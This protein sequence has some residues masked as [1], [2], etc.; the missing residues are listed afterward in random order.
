MRLLSKHGAD[1]NAQ[2]EDGWTPV[3]ATAENDDIEEGV[4]VEVLKVL[5]ESGANIHTSRPLEW[6]HWR[7]WPVTP[8]WAAANNSFAEVVK[9]MGEL[10]VDIVSTDEDGKSP[11][12]V[13]LAGGV[14][15]SDTDSYG[16][17]W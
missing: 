11:L 2:D 15:E 12:E 3:Y 1:L 4:R 8:V 9:A 10:G 16:S 14:D 5:H 17:D 7:T 6:P 13:A